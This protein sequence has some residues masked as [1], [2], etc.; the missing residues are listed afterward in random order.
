MTRNLAKICLKAY[1]INYS[2]GFYFD[3]L[4]NYIRIHVITSRKIL[5]L[6]YIPRT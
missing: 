6:V 4:T 3:L 2:D 5:F 1:L